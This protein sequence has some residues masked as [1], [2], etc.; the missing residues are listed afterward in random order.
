MLFKNNKK[1]PANSGIFFSVTVLFYILITSLASAGRHNITSLPYT[2]SQTGTAYSETLTVNGTNLT[3]TTNGIYFTGH[4]IVFYLVDDT[5]TFAATNGASSY[6]GIRFGNCYNIKVVGGTIISGATD[7]TSNHLTCLQNYISYHD[8]TFEETKFIIPSGQNQH[9]FSGVSSA[10]NVTF[11]N[12]LFRNKVTAYTSRCGM[13][14]VAIQLYHTTAFGSQGN[15][16]GYYHFKFD[17]CKFDTAYGGAFWI[18]G[19]KFLIENCT[20]YVD[21]RNDYYTYPDDGTCH[22]TTNNGHMTTV[23]LKAGSYIKNCHMVSEFNYG[24]TD[25]GILLQLTQGSAANPVLVCSNYVDVKAGLDAH[26]GYMNSKAFKSRY[27]NKH[28]NIFDNTFIAR[29]GGDNPSC[30]AVNYISDDD[31]GCD[32]ALGKYPDSFFVFERN[33]IEAIALDGDFTSNRAVNIVVTDDDGYIWS[34][35]GN[36]WRYNHVKSVGNIY[37]FGGYDGSSGYMLIDKDTVEFNTEDYGKTR[38]TFRVGWWW[39]CLG[40]IARDCYFIG[41]A[42]DTNIQTYGSAYEASMGL[43]RT[44]NISVMGNNGC[45]VGNANVT[46]V[47]NYGR[48]VISGTTSPYGLITGPV[49]YH[50][51]AR[52]GPDS[53]NFNDFTI[54]AG[55]SGETKV[56]TLTV[57]ST[58]ASATLQFDNVAGDCDVDNTPPGTIYDLNAIPGEDHGEIILTWTASGD[59][60]DVGVADHYDIRY[61][62]NAIFESNWSSANSRPNPP[63]P[64]SPGQIQ[65]CTI[66][67]LAEGEAYFIAI[68]TYDDYDNSSAISNSPEVF[69]AGIAVPAQLATDIDAESYTVELKS[70]VV[71]SYVPLYYKFMLDSLE[72]YPGPMIT[73]DLLADVV[74]TATYSE[75]STDVTYYWRVC[76]VATD[77]SDSSSW[78]S[79]TTFNLMTG[80]AQ[81]LAST[82]CVFPLNGDIVVSKRPFLEVSN[83]A[84]ISQYYFQLSDN[85]QFEF[86][87]ESDAIAKSSGLTTSWQVPDP[88]EHG[89]QYF[90]R[91]SSDGSAWTSALA[92]TVELNIHTY[93]NPFRPSEGHSQIIFTN[94]PENAD[95]T[96][97]TISGNIILRQGDIGPN[98]WAWD[99]TNES[100][101]DLA[102]GVYLYNINFPSGSVGGKVVVVR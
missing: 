33:N 6:Y 86:P 41:G 95:L 7:T 85:S 98:D 54:T 44:L 37:E 18:G 49:T 87:V 8:V 74:A 19:G 58:Q 50:F 23:L 11:N 24:G 53:L 66:D 13:D 27:C 68:K 39:D 97:S 78:S 72:N 62:T 101:T 88:L 45:P 5:V 84:D 42:N 47:N 26:Y 52:S 4:D 69:A 83:L 96:I 36:V 77:N 2:A 43:Q 9:C 40:N 46:A 3:S 93:P 48:T 29:S 61:S 32:W 65:T 89:Q 12:C 57:T 64:A 22:G 90:W 16:D 91:V 73:L 60:G 81:T 92:F 59:D 14:G 80:V 70:S 1:F 35:A 17:G 10:Y 15:Q 67:G 51:E 56:A 79:S 28:V 38:Y 99:V 63:T 55:K 31:V 20:T 75:L 94:L 100:G 102:P 30:E 34:D 25:I 82:D 71:E 76:A 21:N